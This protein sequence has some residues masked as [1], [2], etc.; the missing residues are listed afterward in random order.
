MAIRKATSS[1]RK[2]ILSVRSTSSSSTS[3]AAQLSPRPSEMTLSLDNDRL[4][5]LMLKHF[6]KLELALT[7]FNSKHAGI[8]KANILRTLLLPFL[9]LLPSLEATFVPLSKI[10]LSFVSLSTT[11]L[12]E[13]WRLLLVLL[14]ASTATSNGIVS[15]T[16]RSA[17]LECVS[18]IMG[19]PEWAHADSA[20]CRLYKQYLT[21]TLDYCINRLLLTKVISI[22]LSA[23]VGKVFAYAYFHLPNVCNALLFLL[24]VKQAMV[25]A[26]LAGVPRVAAADFKDAAR[27]FPVHLSHLID[28]RGLAKLDRLKRSLI[29]SIPP[30][31]HP[32][33]GI[34]EPGGSWVRRWCSSDSDIFNS[35]FRH[36]VS[37]V[38]NLII[39][40]PSLV[41]DSF[42]GFHIITSHIYQIFLVSI[43]RILMVMAKPAL[44]A[45]NSSASSISSSASSSSS[46][47]STSSSTSSPSSSSSTSPSS[48]SLNKFISSDGTAPL[49][50]T[51]PYKQN[52]TNYT[53]IMK[54]FKTVRD[55]DYSSVVFSNY[56]TRY[57]DGLL[58]K[59]AKTISVFDFNKNGLLLNLVYE[60]SNH[61]LD[62]TNINWE[63]WLGC[64]Y[65]MLTATEHIQTILRSIAF[66]FNVWD[67]IP[68]LLTRHEFPQSVSYLKGWLF[69][70]NESY[71]LNFSDWLTSNDVWL[72]YFTHWNCL[73]RGYY[74][75][76]LVWRIMGVNNYQSSVSIKTTRRAKYKLDFIYESIRSLLSS[77]GLTAQLA[78]LNFSAELPMLNRKLSILPINSKFAYS[79][80]L[81]TLT[82]VSAISKTSEL[83][84]THPYEIFDE[85]IYTCT[86][87]PSSPGDPN[88]TMLGATLP[89][90]KVPRNHSLINLLS[91]FFKMLSTDDPGDNNS[92]SMVPP[93]YI[94]GDRGEKGRQL[95]KT[96][97]SKSMT[98][99]SNYSMKS[100]SSSPSMISF[101]SSP[102]SNTD[103]STDSSLKSD[104]DNSSLLSDYLGSS[105]SS[106]YSASS[107][108]P[109]QPPELFKIPPEIVR[110]IFK[111]DIVLD[112]ESVGEKFMLMQRAN[113]DRMSHRFFENLS[114]NLSF[115]TMPKQ[116][117]IPSVSIYL[118]SDM[119]NKFY[120]TREDYL[121]DDD[122]MSDVDMTDLQ[123]FSKTLAQSLHTPT[124]LMAMGRSLNE[125]NKIV[126]E[127]EFYL[128]N[129][130]ETD[131]A[132]YF[133]VS[134]NDDSD[135]LL[136]IVE[137][138]EGDYFKRIIP[139]LSIDTFSEVK[140]LNAA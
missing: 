54:L 66:L 13:W 131:Q 65:L 35:F 72:V 117:V 115:A 25:D 24:N 34:R 31:K 94:L 62:A 60:Y 64:N 90:Q 107:Q 113:T 133:P 28:Y 49:P 111:F 30:P 33:A 14:N 124:D 137:I 53:S 114:P 46:S 44:S 81:L 42:P 105:S 48:T 86:S 2:S 102:N 51:F 9:R 56:L 39:S 6:K 17:Y 15:S 134:T 108:Q 121:L 104:L 22:S 69:D 12:G 21:D 80:D 75:R 47:S 52:D 139:F 38:D 129:K 123:K 118:N 36:Y 92:F 63:F 29:N 74:S 120:I 20:Y 10:Y 93:N 45:K 88:A 135:V 7:K 19:R 83:R 130:V 100:R 8:T 140:S 110:P 78:N 99:L 59:V 11:V 3:L 125:W 50:T 79:N 27:V 16:D 73:V 55:I 119:Y 91:K 68:A 136:T 71:K 41:P 5:K 116:P 40:C 84:K 37:I 103:G 23:F 1:R 43:H 32:V 70:P 87:L 82:A 128:F 76:L 26:H 106:S 89:S 58:I 97:L 122:A 96:R 95:N 77:R 98:S 127:F 138:N 4:V 85:A 101:Q 126:Q 18:R 57:I 109:S 112:H 67:K 132:N 61:V